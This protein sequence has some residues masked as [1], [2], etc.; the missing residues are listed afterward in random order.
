MTEAVKIDKQEELIRR[1]FT[2]GAHLGFSR[3]RRH[4]SVDKFIYGYKNNTA[5]IDLE[6]TVSSLDR[7][8]E[9]MAR[10]GRERSTIIFVGNKPEARLAIKKAA[11]SIN[12]PYVAYRWIGGTLTN[13]KQIKS[14]I[15]RLHWL[16][17]A[18]STGE[19]AKY[20]KK[21]RLVLAKERDDLER[22][23][24]GIYDLTA[25][26]KALFVVDAKAEDIA[27]AEARLLNIPVVTLSSSDCDIRGIDYPIIGND[28]ARDAVAFMADTLA[29]A[30]REGLKTA[31]PV[32]EN[33]TDKKP[34]DR[35]AAETTR[36]AV[37][38]L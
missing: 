29:T 33:T 11:A 4:P 18:E 9:F 14:R 16:K 35:P 28:T 6:K 20:K 37:A 36:P 5:V 19:L 2:M 27:V 24:E 21:E 30:Y 17:E 8:C 15:D 23:F 1:L 12:M 26:P 34:E 10:L 22:Y 38:K 3:R 31:S 7:A 32:E 13:F 25:L